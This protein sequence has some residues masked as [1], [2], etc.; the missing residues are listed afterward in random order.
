[1]VVVAVVVIVVVVVV[2]VVM[3]MI[4]KTPE[5]G[6]YT[7]IYMLVRGAPLPP[8]AALRRT[9]ASDG[10]AAVTKA[11]VTSSAHT[12]IPPYIHTLYKSHH[13]PCTESQARH[14]T[15]RGEGR[16]WRRGDRR[17]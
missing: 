2:V 17:G 16:R 4:S 10:A 6:V 8:V 12:L 13:A 11:G 14:C 15:D 1:M 7:Y 5:K 9:T 3:M